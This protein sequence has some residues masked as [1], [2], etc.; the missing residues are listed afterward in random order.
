MQITVLGCSGG[1]DVRARTTCFL[2]DDDTLIDAGTG[3]FDLPLSV[4]QRIDHV[5][6]THAHL[7]H[8]AALP[9]LADTAVRQRMQQGRGPIRV[10]ALPEVLKAMHEHLFNQQIWPDFTVLPTPAQPAITLVPVRTGERLEWSQGRV[11]EVLPALHSVPAVGYAVSHGGAHWAFTGDTGRNPALWQR[12][13]ALR[14]AGTPVR[15]LVTETTFSNADQSFADLSGHLT[16][17]A[18]A[19]DLEALDA[20][21]LELFLSHIKPGDQNA[22]LREL[23]PLREVAG[24]KQC[25]L[26]LLQ[27]GQ[28][29]RF[30]GVPASGIDNDIVL[31]I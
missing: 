1:M 11:I 28:T 22:I 21:A 19:E 10:Y 18:L 29:F 27:Q 4:Q 23:E 6:I 20:G 26:H 5:F 13:N 25:R 17:A 24:R 3:L 7:D 8:I 14:A 31:N 12:L 2:I 9:L 30:N 15:W 16:A